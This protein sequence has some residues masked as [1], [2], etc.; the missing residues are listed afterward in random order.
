MDGKAATV[1][2]GP[3]PSEMIVSEGMATGMCSRGGTGTR[4]G[5]EIKKQTEQDCSCSVRRKIFRG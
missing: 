1:I 5:I 3:M 4:T 2:G